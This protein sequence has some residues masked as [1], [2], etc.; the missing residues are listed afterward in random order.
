MGTPN[1][2][3]LSFL[4][5]LVMKL[6]KDPNKVLPSAVLV[7]TRNKIVMYYYKK[8]LTLTTDFLKKQASLQLNSRP[9]GCKKDKKH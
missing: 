5:S 9:I 2:I 3:F 4:L 8:K 1:K 7:Q 6:H